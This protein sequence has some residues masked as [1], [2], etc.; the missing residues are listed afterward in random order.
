MSHRIGLVLAR[1]HRAEAEVMKE[2]AR[3]SAKECGLEVADEVW[4]P[5]MME[6]PLAAKRL[7]MKGGLSGLAILGI[8]ERGETKHGLVMAHAVTEALIGLQLSFMAPIGTAILGPEI[9]PP[10]IASRLE[11]YARAAVLAVHHMLSE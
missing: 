9:D 11:P 4:I 5:G 2:E 1:F 6:A 7:L 8:I 3:R 10:Q